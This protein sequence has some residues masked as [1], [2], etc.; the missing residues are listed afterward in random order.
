MLVPMTWDSNAWPVMG[1]QGMV[2]SE[3]ETD[4]L[5][6]LSEKE[7]IKQPIE[8][9]KME[10]FNTSKLNLEWNFSWFEYESVN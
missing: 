3:V 10:E 4:C 8:Y 9:Y 1:N 6:L 2:E 7:V 5:P